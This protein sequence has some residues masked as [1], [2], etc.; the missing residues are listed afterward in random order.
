MTNLIP[1]RSVVSS[2]SARHTL[3]AVV[4][5][6]LLAGG[7]G[8]STSSTSPSSPSS[9][10]PCVVGQV[11]TNP[12]CVNPPNLL[13]VTIKNGVFS[14][15]PVTVTV[16]QVVNWL[17]SDG[18]AHTATDPGVFDTGVIDPGSAHGANG[19]GVAFNTV[20]TFNYYCTIHPNETASVVVI[21]SAPTLVRETDWRDR[22]DPSRASRSFSAHVVDAPADLTFAVMRLSAIEYGVLEVHR[23]SR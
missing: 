21:S 14:P 23:P 18:I 19:D 10:A 15:N 6:V 3:V 8:S 20:G 13:T 7:C 1:D 4:G 17:N 22:A 9:T 16:G 2:I 5:L 12:E 11:P